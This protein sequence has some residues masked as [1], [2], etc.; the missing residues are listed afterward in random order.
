VKLL[1]DK[2]NEKEAFRSQ[3]SRGYRSERFN[4]FESLQSKTFENGESKESIPIIEQCFARGNYP[5]QTNR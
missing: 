3:T 2:I 5:T 1:S 4:V